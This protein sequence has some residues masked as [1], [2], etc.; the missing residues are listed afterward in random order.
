[1]R[2]LL[3][4][5]TLAVL[6]SGC[7]SV[8]AGNGTVGAGGSL[9]GSP[10]GA[11][12]SSA[13]STPAS[14]APPTPI[15]SGPSAP[16]SSAAT[17][18]TRYRGDQFS[19]LL[20]GAPIADDLPIKTRR[21]TVTAHVLSVETS[22]TEAYIVAYT[23]Y[24]STSLLSLEGAVQGAAKKVGGPVQGLQ[25]ITYHGQPGRDFRVISPRGLT[26]FIRL[27]VVGHRLYQVQFL[28]QGRLS[29]P[30]AEYGT[31]RDSLRF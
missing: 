31:V 27:V 5:L 10:S 23:D 22:P 15:S 8:V 30:P 21:G 4:A 11:A 25:R 9:A 29:A 26:V 3:A 19:I 6:V 20:P 24:P 17:G 7:S 12:P 28:E 16:A 14:S 13:P 18:L 2:S 1:M